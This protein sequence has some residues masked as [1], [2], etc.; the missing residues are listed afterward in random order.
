MGEGMELEAI[1]AV[2]MGGTLLSGG[3]GTLI[4]S[5]LGAIFISSVKSGLIL[6]GAPAFWYQTFVGI[7]LITA[8]IFNSLIARRIVK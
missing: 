5:F 8:V 1:T 4:G 6:I 7:S 2:V 3:Y